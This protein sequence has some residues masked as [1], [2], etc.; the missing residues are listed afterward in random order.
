MVLFTGITDTVRFWVFVGLF[1][2]FALAETLW[3]RRRLTVPKSERWYANIGI[4]LVDTLVVRLLFPLLPYTL[5]ITAFHQNWGIFNRINLTGRPELLL[6]LVL[7]D[8]LIYLQHRLFHRIPLFWRIHRM[9]HTDLDLDVST[10]NRFHPI[11]IAL[12]LVIKMAAVLLFG[13]SA[14]AILLFEVILNAT[15]L[16]SHANLALPVPLDRW[17]RLVLV[18]PD[19][20]R[21]HHSIHPA[22]TDSNF[23][24]CQPWWDRLLGT[25][26]DQPRD[27]HT[28]MLIG[29]REF[30]DQ[31]HLGLLQLLKLPFVTIPPVRRVSDDA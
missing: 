5:A 27:G 26:H 30:R 12:S 4:I 23:G 9:H 25:Y 20:H 6:S 28:G 16:F 10:G 19:M 8:L 1:V 15:S 31:H 18:T 24:F 21:V 11:E 7:L 3:P 14:M 22:E 17:L 29:L 2:L 13:I